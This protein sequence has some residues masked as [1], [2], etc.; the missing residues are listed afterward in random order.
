V[1][2][3]RGAVAAVLALA[4]LAGPAGLASGQS[5]A[6]GV[7]ILVPSKGYFFAHNRLIANGAQIAADESGRPG[8]V[9]AL[10]ISLFREQIPTHP[11]AREVIAGLARRGI[12][13]VVL[14]CNVDSAPALARA[15]SDRGL[16]VLSPCTPDPNVALKTPHVW[17]TAMSG[18]ELAAVIVAYALNNN[19]TTAYI[20]TSTAPAYTR[21]MSRYFRD[22]ARLDGVKIVGVGN[23]SLDH[24]N[25]D[26]I[27]RAVERAQPRVIFTPIFSP[28][29][30]PILAK[31]RARGIFV[32]VYA[33][34][35]LDAQQLLS[36]YAKALD[37]V[38]YGTFG[39]PRST[40][41]T[42]R[43]AYE[44][45]FRQKLDGSFPGLGYETIRI[46][47]AAAEHANS[48]DPMAIDAAFERGFKVTGV[49][50][51]DVVY[52]GDGSK[53]PSTFAGLARV[54]YG[55]DVVLSAMDPQSTVKIPAP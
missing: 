10:R 47:S 27:V 46:L 3:V 2:P 29:L 45:T 18:N 4:A 17:P 33:T 16:L 34:E 5:G 12:G 25:V 7:A 42:F 36:R 21:T 51:G 15:G 19:A 54:L 20:L 52:H 40:S 9:G 37:Q 44:E 6:L 43:T 41:R 48:A 1:R 26:A 11:N 32:P 22:A 50:L 35:G 39:F 14:P 30:Q 23:V 8:L 49:A 24:P 28:Y 53:D 13:V 31:L 38:Y 55:D